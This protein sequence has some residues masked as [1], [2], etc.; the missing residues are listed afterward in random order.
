MTT[1]QAR[2][3]QTGP[4]E[5]R[6][7][8][9]HRTPIEQAGDMMGTALSQTALG[10]RL[11]VRLQPLELRIG[12]RIPAS[13]PNTCSRFK[14]ENRMLLRLAPILLPL[15]VFA[16]TV[17]PEVDQALHARVSEFMQ[18]HVEGK[19]TKAFEYV[20]ED[21]KEY[22][23]NTQKLQYIS[24]EIGDVTYSDNFT[25][26]TVNA[27]VEHTWAIQGQ[28]IKVKTPQVTT[29]ILENGKWVWHYDPHA[30]PETPMGRSAPFN[31]DPGA[32]PP[33]PKVLTQAEIDKR[34]EEILKG[35]SV[36]KTEVTLASDKTSSDQI[37][38]HNG[39]P[40]SVKVYLDPG[41]KLEGFSAELEKSDLNMGQDA[42]VKVRYEPV[43]PEMKPAR[44]LRIMV[45]PFN[46]VLEV[47]VKFAPSANQ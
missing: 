23:F 8:T 13:Q 24:F 20:A 26:A 5:A 35:S 30:M 38:F 45:L 4:G 37:V 33:P 29:W 39:F 17:P 32:A 2:L 3:F 41:A 46:Q 34:A 44:L 19:F 28:K 10:R 43:S 36:D 47:R 42:V 25:K 7:N 22:Y 9:I 6:R 31:G 40:G 27:M 12:V 21:T 1:W 18:Y 11:T 15:A 14:K 16:Q